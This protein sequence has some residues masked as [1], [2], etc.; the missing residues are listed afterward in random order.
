MFQIVR[1]FIAKYISENERI[2][3]L[4]NFKIY[5]ESKLEIVLSTEE[6]MASVSLLSNFTYDFWAVE[7]ESERV[8]INRTLEM[9]SIEEVIKEINIDLECFSNLKIN[10]DEI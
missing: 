2:I 1:E 7:F 10:N 5:N 6:H 4:D 9:G 8:V 3:T